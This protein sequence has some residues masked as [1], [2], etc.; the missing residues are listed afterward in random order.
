MHA[1][2]ATDLIPQMQEFFLKPIFSQIL[3]F[4]CE[5]ADHIIIAILLHSPRHKF[6]NCTELFPGCKL[7]NVQYI[8]I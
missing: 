6:K 2:S 8:F 1:V 5:D 4:E 7:V 3:N